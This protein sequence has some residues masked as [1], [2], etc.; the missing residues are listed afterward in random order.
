MAYLNHNIPPFSAYIKNEYKNVYNEFLDSITG[1]QKAGI[2][3]SIMET[4]PPS[5]G[6]EDD[7]FIDYGHLQEQGAIKYTHFLAKQIISND[8][9][10][11]SITTP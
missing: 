8:M 11:K 1:Y 10:I 7:L 3:L 9:L 2:H 5:Y 4:L 6:S